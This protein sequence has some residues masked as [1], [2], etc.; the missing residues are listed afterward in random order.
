MISDSCVVNTRPGDTDVVEEA[1]L[2][3]P[4]ALRHPRVQLTG[5]GI[6]EEQRPA[7]GSRLPDGHL[8]QRGEHFVERLH[9]RDRPRDVQQRLGE[10]QALRLLGDRRRVRSRQPTSDVSNRARSAAIISCSCSRSA[11][12]ALLRTLVPRCRVF[13]RVVERRGAGLRRWPSTA[14]ARRPTARARPAPRRSVRR[15]RP[16]VAPAARRHSPGLAADRASCRAT[17]ALAFGRRAG[18]RPSSSS[19]RSTSTVSRSWRISARARPS[20][21]SVPAD[22]ICLA[23]SRPSASGRCSAVRVPRAQPRPAGLPSGDGLGED[24]RSMD[25]T[26]AT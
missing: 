13:V 17:A 18:H 1:D 15:L 23:C 24:H 14:P 11:R 26:T 19:L 4:L 5:R 22:T 25:A 8:D 12:N 2:A 3:G 9:R 20:S 7:V 21:S 16:R 10:V 6:V